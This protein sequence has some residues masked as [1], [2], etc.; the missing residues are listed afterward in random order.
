[1]LRRE[2]RTMEP[3]RCEVCEGR[4]RMYR[5]TPRCHFGGSAVVGPSRRRQ[6]LTWCVA[7]GGEDSQLAAPA[8]TG[9]AFLEVSGSGW[10]LEAVLNAA[11]IR[12][13]YH[14]A[15]N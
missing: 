14:L 5:Q 13:Q 8:L 9:R 2:E 4:L 15:R 10:T 1:V 7:E 3:P 12:V 11:P 6:E